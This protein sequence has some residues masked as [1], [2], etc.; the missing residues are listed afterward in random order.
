MAYNLTNLTNSHTL[1]SFLTSTNELTG[2]SMAIV[3]LIALFVIILVATIKRDSD[4]LEAFAAAAFITSL[5]GL[6]FTLAGLIST[7]WIAFFII[8]LGG[9]IIAG[10]VKKH[11]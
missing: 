8:P 6:L 9:V 10:F 4:P 7:K 3:I 11:G 2:G 5:G 1:L